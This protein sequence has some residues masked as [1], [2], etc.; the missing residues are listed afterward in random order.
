MIDICKKAQCLSF[1]TNQRSTPEGAKVNVRNLFLF[2]LRSLV[3][4][5]CRDDIF[6][7]FVISNRR[8]KSQICLEILRYAQYDTIS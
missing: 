4:S 2:F 5:L 8:E 1:R 3:A 7:V 6:A